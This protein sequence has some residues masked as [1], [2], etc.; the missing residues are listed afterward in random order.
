MKI[1]IIGTVIFLATLAHAEDAQYTWPNTNRFDCTG[2][3]KL[4]TIVV[5]STSKTEAWYSLEPIKGMKVRCDADI[6][7]ELA[8][9]VLKT[10]STENRCEIKGTIAGHG[11]Y[12]WTRI[13]SVRKLR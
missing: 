11:A 13:D 10:C 9:R 8:G 1:F 2:T 12:V 6:G 4:N 3:L 5:P 7:P